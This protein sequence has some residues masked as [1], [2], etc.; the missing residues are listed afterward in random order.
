MIIRHDVDPAL[1]LIDSMAFPAVVVVDSFQE[2]VLVTYDKIDELLK[3]SLIPQIQPEPE[4]YT[5]CDGMGTLIR[6]DWILSAAH[7]VTE[8]AAE[9]EISL[10]DKIYT[11][12]QIVVHPRFRNYGLNHEMAEHDIALIELDQPVKDI[13][14]MPLYEQKDE[15]HKVVIFVGRGDFGTGLTGPDNA[16]GKLRKATN[17]IEASNQQWLVFRFDVPPNGTDLEGISGPGDRGGPAL[18]QQDEGWAIAGISSGQISRLPPGNLGEGRYGVMEYYT[19]VSCY[20]DWIKSV[21][22]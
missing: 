2:Q 20:L 4:F 10:K 13:A 15:L 8:L 9:K 7:V 5:R 3:P 17:R 21:V 1:Y 12:Q 14:P 11:I 19:R 18:I 6:P 22:D 16:D